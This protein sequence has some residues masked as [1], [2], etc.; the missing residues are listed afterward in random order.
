VKNCEALF[1]HQKSLTHLL[2]PE[3]ETVIA[4]WLKEAHASSSSVVG[5]VVKEK[6]LF[7]CLFESRQLYSF[8]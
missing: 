2:L 6:G 1:K 7:V 4:V 8:E 3:L 5:A